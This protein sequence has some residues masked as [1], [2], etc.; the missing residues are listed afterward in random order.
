MTSCP[1]RL[2]RDL[3]YRHEQTAE[4]IAVIIKHPA[5]RKF[6]R[7]EEAEY[8]IAQQLDGETPF[9]EIRKRTEGQFDAELPIEALYAFIQTLKKNGLLETEDALKKDA[10][11]K[12]KRFRGTALYCRIQVCDPCE[13]LKWLARHTSFFFKSHFVVLS[14]LSIL[15][16]KKKEVDRKSTRLNSSHITI[17][18][19]VFCLKKKKKKKNNKI[20]SKN[21]Q[22]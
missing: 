12:P 7:L 18:Y 3:T 6:F 2:R 11:R 9:E 1:P 19:A 17:S 22:Y 14:T 10:S 15:L 8:F 21:T 4:G 16:L 5:S 20:N 13:L